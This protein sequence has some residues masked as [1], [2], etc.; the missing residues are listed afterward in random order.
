[1]KNAGQLHHKWVGLFLSLMSKRGKVLAA[2]A[3]SPSP[4]WNHQ[5]QCPGPA[6]HLCHKLTLKRVPSWNH[7]WLRPTTFSSSCLLIWPV[8]QRSPTELQPQNVS[9]P[10]QG[11]RALSTSVSLS[12]SSSL[13]PWVTQV[14]M[15]RLLARL[16]NRV[17]S[18][19]WDFSRSRWNGWELVSLTSLVGQC[20]R[21]KRGTQ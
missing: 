1:M 5:A 12:W 10:R 7:N 3:S 8:A 21:R 20:G 19:P 14:C 9:R 6:S 16:A 15:P 13:C 2:E 18:I 4:V 11:F 17:N